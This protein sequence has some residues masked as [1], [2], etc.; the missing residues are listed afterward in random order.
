[1]YLLLVLCVLNNVEDCISYIKEN[2]FIE[3]VVIQIFD[4]CFH[5]S[6]IKLK[7]RVVSCTA[8][9]HRNLLVVKFSCL[10]TNWLEIVV[11]LAEVL[12]VNLLCLP[13]EICSIKVSVLKINQNSCYCG[14]C[15]IQ[16]WSLEPR[17]TF[18]QAKYPPGATETDPR[19]LLVD[20]F[21]LLF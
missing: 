17:I 21:Q 9:C 16:R 1:M 3:L 13:L 19:T 8:H 6:T 15:T 2:C 20:Y 12:I 14:R 18:Q 4:N 10:A 5:V 7:G 11:H